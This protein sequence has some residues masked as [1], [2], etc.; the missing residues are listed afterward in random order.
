MIVF[1]V[2]NKFQYGYFDRLDEFMRNYE[3]SGFF[4]I[5]CLGEETE[6]IHLGDWVIVAENALE[7]SIF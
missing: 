5:E 4:V 1:S 7:F 2:V 3:G 6:H